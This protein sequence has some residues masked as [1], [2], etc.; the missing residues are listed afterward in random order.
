MDKILKGLPVSR[1]IYAKI[2]KQ[3]ARE[4]WNPKLAIIFVGNDPAADYYVKMLEKKSKKVGILVETIKLGSAVTQTDFLQ[5]LGKLNNDETVNGIMIQKPLPTQIDETVINNFINPQK[6]VDAFHPL[7]LGKMFL[8]E[9]TF[10]P[11]TPAAVLEILKFYEISTNGKNV[12]I[13]GRS[14]VV[15][16]PLANLLLR[17]DETGNATVT[18]CHSRTKKMKEITR[19][20]DI[21]IAAIGRPKF[22]SKEMIKESAVVI[23][24]GVNQIVTGE[25]TTSYVGDV[26][27]KNCLEKTFFMTPVPGGVGTVTTAKLLQNVV[28]AIEFQKM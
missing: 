16:K 18:I 23:D 24:V 28:K 2:K 7:N 17:K 12:V 3:I 1:K 13:L 21:L 9:D 14:N 8:D 22:V 19:N 4:K 5:V 27:Y 6:D 26:D 10:I 20:A 25:N 15:G 11:C